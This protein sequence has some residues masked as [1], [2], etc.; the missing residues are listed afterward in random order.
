MLWSTAQPEIQR[1]T[2]FYR[3]GSWRWCCRCCSQQHWCKLRSVQNRSRG[4]SLLDLRDPDG[5]TQVCIC[6]CNGKRINFLDVYS[7]P[8]LKYFSFLKQSHRKRNSPLTVEAFNIVLASTPSC[9]DIAFTC[10]TS[11]IARTGPERDKRE[12]NSWKPHSPENV[13]AFSF[14]Q[15]FLHQR[16]AVPPY[17][18]PASEREWKPGWHRS[19][20]SPITPGLQLHW[21]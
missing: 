13:S 7:R 21:P 18:H 8:L 6:I 19:H 3:T 20:L 1:Q 4:Y 14:R 16:V 2:Q 10:A 12:D 5:K 11:R 17:L 15:R 9:F